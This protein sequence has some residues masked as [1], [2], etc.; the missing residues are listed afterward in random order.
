MAKA[1]KSRAS[2]KKI[3]DK[4]KSKEW[5]HVLAPPVFDRRE[6]AE[7]LADDPAKL[8]GRV[9]LTTPNEIA[10]DSSSSNP[11]RPY[12]K[13]FLQVHDVK[14]KT[15]ETRFVGHEL[16]SDYIRRLA[17]RRK[18]KVDVVFDVKA[19]DETTMQL[20]LTAIADKRIQGS[21]ETALRHA[22]EASSG[23]YVGARDINEVVRAILNG[24]LSKAVTQHCKMIYPLRRIEVSKSEVGKHSAA[25][26][27]APAA[28]AIGEG[29]P[30]P[31]APATGEVQ[32]ESTAADE[33]SPPTE[34][35]PPAGDQ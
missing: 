2:A 20:K 8:M 15:C 5:Y 12:I 3:K 21:Q 4:W 27:A 26:P 17:R 35:E 9:V 29:G 16:T 19:K 23:E 24:D 28:P 11:A 14:D 31:E 33:E 7:T 34:G 22:V 10:P 30:A 25:Q 18:T 13:L 6:V 1:Q 32:D